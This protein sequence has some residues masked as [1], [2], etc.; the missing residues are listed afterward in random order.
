VHTVFAM[1]VASVPRQSDIVVKEP[2]LVWN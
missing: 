1:I 2:V